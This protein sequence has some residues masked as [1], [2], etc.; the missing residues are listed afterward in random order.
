MIGDSNNAI[1]F[2]HKL[3]VIDRQF[4]KLP[5]AFANNSSA[6]IKLLITQLTKIVISEGFLSVDFLNH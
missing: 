2:S 4:L 6:N 3:L 1:N 5:T